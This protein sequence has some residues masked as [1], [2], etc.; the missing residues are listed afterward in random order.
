MIDGLGA[1]YLSNFSTVFSS[2]HFCCT[3]S[4]FRLNFT[5][6]SAS[7]NL[8]MFRL[9]NRDCAHAVCPACNAP[10]ASAVSPTTKMFS[11]TSWMS[12]SALVGGFLAI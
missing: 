2:S 4:I 1:S 9:A 12:D 3:I 11:S 5:G 10:K 7:T 6:F 8:A